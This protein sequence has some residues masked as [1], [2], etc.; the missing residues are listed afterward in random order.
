MES[1]VTFDRLYEGAKRF[2]RLAMEAHAEE[3]QEVF[4]LEGVFSFCFIPDCR[5][6]AVHVPRQLGVDSAV[7]R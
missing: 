1:P 7:R 6:R 3:D 5:I 2:A 4:P